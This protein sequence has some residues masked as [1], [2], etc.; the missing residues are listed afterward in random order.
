MRYEV[1]EKEL[2][3]LRAKYGEYKAYWNGDVDSLRHMIEVADKHYVFI[4]R[5]WLDMTSEDE[6][7]PDKCYVIEAAR[8]DMRSATYC[9]VV[10][11]IAGFYNSVEDLKKRYNLPLNDLYDEV[12][13]CAYNNEYGNDDYISELLTEEE[14]V[15][16]IR[17]FCKTVMNPNAIFH[18]VDTD[19]K[20]YD[21]Q[22]VTVL[23]PLD[24]RECDWFDVGNMYRIEFV[25]GRTSDAFED[26]LKFI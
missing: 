9:D 8:V 26:E 15:Q 24:E 16:V 17:M 1:V 11:Y 10:S 18:T 22:E 20:K 13:S 25:D 19:L 23:R 5:V 4:E 7:Y 21:G 3:R 2:S 14:S 6:G 12:A